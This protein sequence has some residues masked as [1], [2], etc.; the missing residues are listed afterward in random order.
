VSYGRFL[1]GARVLSGYN[2]PLTIGLEPKQYKGDRIQKAEDGGQMTEGKIGKSGNQDN[3]VQVIRIAGN[4]EK[5]P[6]CPDS[7][8]P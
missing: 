4:Q 3:R 5:S 6:R 1:L 7:L 8:I 2:M